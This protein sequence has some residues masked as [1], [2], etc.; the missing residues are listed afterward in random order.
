MSYLAWYSSGTPTTGIAPASMGKLSTG[1]DSSF[2]SRNGVHWRDE[3]RD[4]PRPWI[5]LSQQP[6]DLEH[7]RIGHHCIGKLPQQPCMARL[8]FCQPTAECS[9]ARPQRA[10]QIRGEAV[11][12][13]RRHQRGAGHPLIGSAKTGQFILSVTAESKHQ[14]PQH[15]TRTGLA[16][17]LGHRALTRPTLKFRPR[18]RPDGQ[19]STVG[20]PPDTMTSGQTR[21]PGH[22]STGRRTS[23]AQGR[24]TVWGT[25]RR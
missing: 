1:D 23:K 11:V 17:T 21:S 13:C 19:Q 18:P 16:P 15:R 22:D 6:T 24:W 9:N 8:M 20:A 5:A 2:N 3:A 7:R 4:R 25:V 14:C 10:H 12:K